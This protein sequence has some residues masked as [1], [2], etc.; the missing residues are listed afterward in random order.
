MY[1]VL[2]ADYIDKHRI[3]DLFASLLESLAIEKPANPIP[4]LVQ[5][6][7][8][9]IVTLRILVLGG[10]GSGKTSLSARI[11]REFGVE[12]VSSSD[13]LHEVSNHDTQV[14]QC[15]KSYIDKGEAVPDS[16]LVPMLLTAV[17]RPSCKQNGWLLEGF[18]R[19]RDQGNQMLRAGILPNKVIL[20]DLPPAVAKQRILGRRVDPKTGEVFSAN[21]VSESAGSRLQKRSIDTDENAEKTIAAWT[22]DMN[23]TLDLFKRQALIVNAEQTPEQIWK[24]VR[25]YLLTRPPSLAPTRPPRIALIGAPGTGRTTMSHMIAQELNLMHISPGDLL[26]EQIAMDSEIGKLAKGFVGAGLSVPDDIVNTLVRDRLLS[27]EARDRGY[28]LDGFP[29]TRAQAEMMK[30]WNTIPRRVVLLEGPTEALVERVSGRLID[31]LTNRVY[32]VKADPPPPGDIASRCVRREEDDPDVVRHQ[33]KRVKAAIDE[34]AGEFGEIT[35]RVDANQPKR[36]VYETFRHLCI[37]ELPI[38]AP[39][40]ASKRPT[41]PNPV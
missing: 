25:A 41:S 16:I 17:C 28:V 14:G 12:L 20:L 2:A 9:P 24:Q 6:L 18:P 36:T 13:I 40:S 31:P 19:C 35:A 26:R 15:V 7:Q 4:F 38:P 39:T 33:I 23:S 32:H 34:A 5:Q 27:K 30:S 3:W 37:S 10:P 1:T 11:V 29:G 22:K 8:R 21:D